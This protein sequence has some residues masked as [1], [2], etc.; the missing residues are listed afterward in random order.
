MDE[1]DRLL[2]DLAAWDAARARQDEAWLR[3]QA[4]EEARFTGVALD[5]AEQADTVTVLST[6]GRRH[7][8]RIVA[9]AEDFLA[10][11]TAGSAPVLLPYTAVAAVRPSPGGTTTG[12]SRAP[13]LGMRFVH[14][15]AGMAAERPRIAVV[16]HGGESTSG[17]LQS[18]GVDVLT[19][20][21]E[22]AVVVHMRVDA[23]AEV[24]VFG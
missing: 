9:V 17:E 12:S 4:E 7:H 2:A 15:L 18:V 3:R 5:L 23:I 14:A 11:R 16:V 8:G 20:R 10:M 13:L 21:L 1:T 19:L 24:T 22:G 6:T